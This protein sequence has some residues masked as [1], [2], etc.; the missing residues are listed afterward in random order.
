ML[1][2]V[3]KFSVSGEF[4]LYLVRHRRDPKGTP[5]DENGFAVG[6]DKKKGREGTQS[7]RTLHF[8]YLWGGHSWADSNISVHVAP[9]DMI[10]MSNFC[11]TV[12][13]GCQI[14]RGQSPR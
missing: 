14:Y 12:F 11:S 9:H 8:S 2:R 3:P 5:L 7:H 6:D 4:P 1:I 10:N 13:R